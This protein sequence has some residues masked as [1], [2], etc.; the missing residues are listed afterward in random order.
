MGE[1]SRCARCGEP[2]T[3]IPEV[4]QSL[5]ATLQATVACRGCLALWLVDARTR[6]AGTTSRATASL[7]PPGG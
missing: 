6:N 1:V 5:V 2:V 4:V 3:D 7:G